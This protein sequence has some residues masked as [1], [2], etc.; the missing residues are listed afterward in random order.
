MTTGV[1]PSLDPSLAP[2]PTVTAP[3]RLQWVAPSLK[4]P[5]V[6]LLVALS[7]YTILGQQVFYFN[8]SPLQLG[9][10]LLVCMGLDLLITAVQKRVVMLPLSGAITG[11]SLG[12]LLESHL[13]QVFVVAAVWSILS[14]HLIRVRGNHLFNPSNFGIVAA[15][16]LGHGTATV[17]PGSQWGGHLLYAL[18]IL[19]L[20]LMMMKRVHRLPVVVG[21]LGGYLVMGMVRMALGQGGLIYVLGPMTGAEFT[22]FAFSMIPDPKTSP[23]APA[24]QF[25]WGLAIAGLDGL[26]RLGEVRFSMFYALFILCALR[27]LMDDLIERRRRHRGLDPRDLETRALETGSELAG[28]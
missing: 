26:L 5:R 17:A 21:W 10:T 27:P 2:A 4:D 28:A 14:K 11:L 15:I 1:A 25:A 8:R 18:V 12:L 22:L 24:P 3:A 19:C 16:V 23:R 6:T 13:W 20:G 7:T 9:L